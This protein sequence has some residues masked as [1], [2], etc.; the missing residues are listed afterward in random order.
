M[1]EGKGRREKKRVKFS[2]GASRLCSLNKS[3]ASS[4]PALPNSYPILT[5]RGLGCPRTKGEGWEGEEWG[6]ERGGA[7]EERGRVKGRRE[8]GGM[9]ETEKGMGS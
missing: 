8:G 7:G 1:E 4:I 3:F 5:L 2:N 6:G 9:G